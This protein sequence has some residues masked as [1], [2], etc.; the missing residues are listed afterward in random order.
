[1]ETGRGRWP[2]GETCWALTGAGGE[3]GGE[4]RD[5]GAST[6]RSSPAVLTESIRCLL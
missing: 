6:G 5:S 4:G 3:G 1:M 2:W